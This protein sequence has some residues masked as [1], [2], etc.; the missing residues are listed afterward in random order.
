MGLYCPTCGLTRASHALLALDIRAALRYNPLIFP[1]LAVIAYYEWYAALA[2]V[3]RREPLLGGASRW[4]VTLLLIAFGVFF[5]VRNALLLFG[6][7]LV[8]DFIK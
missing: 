4:P 5:L 2:A 3:R 7:D 6:I 8:G 1:L